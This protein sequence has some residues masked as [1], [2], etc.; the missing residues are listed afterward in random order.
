MPQ[1]YLKGPIGISLA[2][3][4]LTTVSFAQ[5]DPG[6]RGGPAGAG[7]KI[8]GLNDDQTRFFNAGQDAFAEVASVDGSVPDTEEGLGP[9]FNLNSCAGCHKFPAVGGSSPAHNPQ[10]DVG[11]HSQVA[12]LVGLGLISPGGPVREI[13]FNKPGDGGVH[14]LFTIVGLPGTPG[15]CTA[16]LLPQPNFAANLAN[17][18]F[19][20]PT[21]TFGA[22]LI[23]AIPDS[24]IAAL[25]SAVKPFGIKG[26][27]NRSGNDGTITRFGW[28]AQNKSLVIF[29]GEAYNVEQG[30]TN[31]LFPDERGEG[32]VQ[33]PLPCRVVHSAQDHTNFGEDSPKNVPSDAVAFANFM[34]FLDAPDPVSYYD[35]VGPGSII[36][37]RSKFTAVGCAACH[38]PMMQTGDH[39]IRALRNKTANLYSDLLVHNMGSG[40]ADGVSQGNAN[41]SEFRT[42]PLWG[43]GKRIFFLHDGRTSD[44]M[45]AIQEHSSPGSEANAVIGNFNALSD[46]DTQDLLNFLRSL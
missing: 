12:T 26:H 45:K 31:E 4:A 3:L 34:R 36:N 2:A 1:V 11:P 5:T 24:A 14:D 33:D 29:S 15:T 6:V 20:I 30:V 8:E 22:G 28:K 9:R 38:T 19:R 35:H 25:E 18:V 21:P 41:G 39:D 44:L 32:G 42:A 37:G 13:R 17:I 10:V 23:E 16:T 43:L 40:L 46:H 27:T 7:G